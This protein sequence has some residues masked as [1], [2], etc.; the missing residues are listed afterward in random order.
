MPGRAE[1]SRVVVGHFT[2]RARGVIVTPGGIG[3]NHELARY[4]WLDRLGK[5]SKFTVPGTSS[6]SH[7][8]V[9]KEATFTGSK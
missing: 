3:G 4:N 8:S 9:A 1:S 5:P 6:Q 2:L 7:E